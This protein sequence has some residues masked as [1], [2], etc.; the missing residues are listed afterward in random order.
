MLKSNFLKIFAKSPVK[1]M[2]QHMEV[3][4]QSVVSLF[5]FFYGIVNQDWQIAKIERDK[6]NLLENKADLLKK[7]IRLHLPNK[8]LLPIDRRDFISLLK[9]QDLIANCAKKLA[10][11][12]FY[13]KMHF[14][15]QIT[16]NILVFIQLDI[17]ATKLAQNVVNE[18]EQLIEVGFRGNE[19][20]LVKNMIIEL[21]HL[22]EKTDDIQNDLR[23]E[24][25]II[26]NNLN[27]IDV[28][29]LYKVI[30]WIAELA[31][32]AQQVGHQLELLLTT[33]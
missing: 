11:L 12:I 14:P 19:T 25:F 4:Y 21:D 8:I 26:E 32:K 1:P 7:N 29:F 17:D 22:D 15:E 10:N 16:K 27:P 31:N 24:L 3:V 9:H 20:A 6:I 18:L 33:K 23:Q 2:Q 30:D 13:R 5:D 28:I